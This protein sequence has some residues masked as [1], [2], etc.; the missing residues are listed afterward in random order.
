MNVR[1]EQ[2]RRRNAVARETTLRRHQR[3]EL[4]QRRVDD[5]E[6]EEKEASAELTRAEWAAGQQA[7]AA[8]AVAVAPSP[9][10]VRVRDVHSR[11]ARLGDEAFLDGSISCMA[12][13][14]R[15]E[16]TTDLGTAVFERASAL[17]TSV[18][19]SSFQP[20]ELLSVRQVWSDMD[21]SSWRGQQKAG[22]TLALVTALRRAHDEVEAP[23][24]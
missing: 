21:H 19:L 17:L 2:V 9:S 8:D 10:P 1:L 14:I 20:P 13:E 18:R 3:L 12:S 23:V 7:R 15:H 22:P 6:R 24:L 16:F 4:N 5:A 11:S